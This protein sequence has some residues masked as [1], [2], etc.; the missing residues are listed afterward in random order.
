[1]FL[2]VPAYPRSPGQRPLN[3]CVC[4]CVCL[5]FPVIV[6]PIRS[7]MQRVTIVKRAIHNAPKIPVYVEALLLTLFTIRVEEQNKINKLN[8]ETTQTS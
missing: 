3:G 5:L 7:R 4:V 6:L 1:M 8:N 2:L